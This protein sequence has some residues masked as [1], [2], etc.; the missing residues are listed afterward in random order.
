MP[1]NNQLLDELELLNFFD[2]NST[3]GGIKIHK[4]AEQSR[5]DAAQRLHQ[6]GVISLSDGGYLTE[7]GVETA[8]HLKA[9]IN[10]LNLD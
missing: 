6:K 3:H 2:L 8:Q 7:R 9:L 10:L 1:I 4:D 5:I